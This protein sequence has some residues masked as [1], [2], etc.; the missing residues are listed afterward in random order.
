MMR[1]S[2]LIAVE[3]MLGL[4]AALAI[5]LGLAWWRLSQGPVELGFLRQQ[6]QSELSAARSGRPVGIERVELAWAPR[7]AVE[8]RAVGVT[9]EDGRGGVLSRSDE[10]RM[11]LAVLPLVVGRI[12]VER[13]EFRGGEITFTHKR[14]GAVHVAFGP[15]GAPPDI[16][17][18]PPP[19]NETL[20][21][22]V[23]RL[24][25]GLEGAFRPVGAGAALRAIRV[26]GADLA[27]IE[28]R[29]GGRW[30]ARGANLELAREGRSLALTAN[31]RLEAPAGGTAPATLRITSDTAFQSAIIEFGA[32]DVRPRALFSQA[33][34]GPFGA[35][36]APMSA[37]ISVGLDRNA[38][39]NRF[40]G[41]AVL[42]RGTA[43]LPDGE[44]TLDGGRFHGRYDIATDE[45]IIDELTLAG[46]QTRVGGEAR[47][48]DVSAIMRA[49]PGA[50]AA[51]DISLP[52]LRLDVPGTFSAPIA[53]SNV[54]VA[55]AI[56][57]GDQS[58]QFSTIE[59]QTG[60]ARIN[61]A[62]RLYWAQA[63][64]GAARRMRPGIE[65]QASIEG[66]LDGRTV[67]AVWPMG[68][69]E[70]ARSFLDRTLV[71]GRVTDAVARLDI[72]P[73]DFAAAQFRNE[74]VDVRFNVT[75]GEM[76]FLSTMSPVTAAR[77]AGILRGNSFEISVPEARINGLTITNGR[78]VLPQFKP[79]GAMA[80]I[81]AR[82]EGNARN[83]LE[84][85]AQEPI[86]LDAR[87]PVDIAS[88]NGH[89]VVN[90]RL[91]RP[92]L[93]EV[94][95]EQ[96]RFSVDGAVRDFAANMSARRVALSQGQL[97]VRGDQ[98][99][100]VVSG[101]IR[102]GSSA[103]DEVRWTEYIGGRRRASSEYQITGDFDADDLQRLGY[104][105]ARFAQG[106]VGV[107]ISGQGRGFDVE[108]AHLDIDL[109]HA[110]VTDPWAF[111]NKRAGQTASLQLDVARQS[112]GGLAFTNLEA[113]G[114]GVFAQGNV[115]L[116]RREQITELDLPRLV[117]EGRSDARLS[118]RRAADGGL[119]L[120]VRGALFD[121]APFMGSSE[122]DRT[123]NAIR[124]SAADPPLRASVV[125]DRLKMRGGATMSSARVT[126]HTNR[127]A[128]ERLAAE[129]RAPAG[130]AFSLMI[131]PEDAPGRLRLRSDD[132]GFAVAAITGAD[133]VVGG[134]ATADGEWRS[135][136]PSRALFNVHLRNFQVVRLPAMARL[137]SS[138]GSLTGLVEMLNG[139]GIGF[140]ALDA[141]MSYANERLTFTEGRMAGPSLGLTGAGAY[142]LERDNLDIDGVIAPSPGLNLSLLG[143]VPVIGDLLVSRRGEGLFGMTYS[144]NGPAGQ[145][146]VGVNPVSALTPGILRRIFEP[147][148]RE[149]GGEHSLVPLDPPPAAA[150]DNSSANESAAAIGQ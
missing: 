88:S 84:V 149:G 7:G 36:D 115:R 64:A 108:N 68:L 42:G 81:S 126:L 8:L 1:R 72:R 148:Q 46:G 111:W 77:G 91:Q 10:A 100:I 71:A 85:L 138:A 107:T 114:A 41:E 92:M 137:L 75:G 133:N 116:D 60:E 28:E 53:F 122:D 58:V 55:G 23:T 43:D 47:L 130:G 150:N 33:A 124:A 98:N 80:T 17:L 37:T 82:V 57:T 59:A 31:A 110:A 73:S 141:E 49:A 69:G 90:L 62:G 25:D 3:I 87:L 20:E 79:K 101:P 6:M 51:F 18:P 40:E 67:A 129:G 11:E 145:P 93:S 139:D 27:I 74:A 12:R 147:V 65:L 127:G 102:A 70:G 117:L 22:R 15:E 63:G 16:I 29:G 30:R 104:S 128:I 34:L 86:N 135:G 61:G 52:S 19:A 132:G 123:A 39:V 4:V 120:S 118:A 134:A 109:T 38:G 119:E 48:R 112:D 89:G 121:A 5:G 125:V 54:R 99:A 50:P 56:A 76:R 103:I 78:V 146:R 9:V 66:A 24:L 136:P 96:W 144:I 21:Q 45:L 14:N 142:N 106:R 143:E 2:T 13:A 44:I 94:P 113:R 26:E 32:H 97:Q 35:L 131:N 83:I 105:I 95:F 140:S